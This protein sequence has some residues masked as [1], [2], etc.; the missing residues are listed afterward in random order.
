MRNKTQRIAEGWPSSP[1]Q[2]SQGMWT[3]LFRKIPASFH[4]KN[5]L[6]I[7]Y[8]PYILS[9]FYAEI[10]LVKRCRVLKGSD[11]IYFLTLNPKVQYLSHYG[12]VILVKL[13]LF[14]S[15]KD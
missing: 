5:I 14:S 8:F 10:L 2:A 11:Y 4:K 3:E 1:H 6:N 13:I 15:I 9:F 12:P 7:M